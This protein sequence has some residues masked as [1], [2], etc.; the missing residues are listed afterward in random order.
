MPR[1]SPD[2]R[3][4][5]REA[6]LSAA[7]HVFARQGFHKATMPDIAQHAGMSPGNLYRYFASK[8]AI[9]EAFAERDLTRVTAGITA[10]QTADDPIEAV[11]ALYEAYLSRTEE[12]TAVSLE[13][14]AELCRNPRVREIYA[15]CDRHYT[16]AMETA[17]VRARDEGSIDPGITPRDAAVTLGALADGLFWRRAVDPSL[18]LSRVFLEV[19]RFVESYLRPPGR[20]ARRS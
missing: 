3:S 12:E 9:I 18:D 19:R 2:A 5:R 14:T 13:I 8:D 4:D 7:M 10:L 1:I 17:L 11:L 20:R 6:I 16:E 15:A